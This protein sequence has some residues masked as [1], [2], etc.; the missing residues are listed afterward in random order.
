[1]K[2][3]SKILL[4]S[5][6]LLSLGCK[7][8]DPTPIGGK[9]GN[10]S[11]TIYPAH[12]GATATLDSMVVY[13]KYNAKDMPADG[14]YDDS[15]TCTIANNLPYAVFSGLTNGNYYIFGKGYDYAVASK[16]KGGIG[17]VITV[18]DP[19]DVHLPVG[20]EVL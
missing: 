20:E 11:L 14:V 4:F 9:G 12:H 15:A 13:I 16:V 8:D 10:A 1:M 2:T 19:Q 5:L 18:Q 17:Y 7:H 6:P 3:I